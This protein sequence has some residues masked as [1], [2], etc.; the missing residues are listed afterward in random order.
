VGEQVKL[1]LKSQDIQHTFTIEE[2]G[3]QVEI[4]PGQTAT[5]E[6][7]G[8]REG[9]YTFFCSVPGHREKGMAGKLVVSQ[10][11]RTPT[12]STGG[13]SYGGGSYDY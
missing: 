4:L 11:P 5:V 10:K 13:G 6:L 9:T 12:G 2:L 1:E 3:I 8:A 7:R